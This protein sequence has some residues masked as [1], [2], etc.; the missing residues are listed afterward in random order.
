MP[1]D[2]SGR[3]AL[4]WRL[5]WFQAGLIQAREGNVRGSKLGNCMFPV[6]KP[7]KIPKRVSREISEWIAAK[8][9]DEA[10]FAG[11]EDDA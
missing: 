6:K 3:G 1:N 9:L 10:G 11:I 4:F 2:T 5:K 7:A 8:V